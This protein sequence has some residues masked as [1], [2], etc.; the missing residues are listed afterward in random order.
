MQAARL[1]TLGRVLA[2][3]NRC[4]AANSPVV[5]PWVKL[6]Y[7]RRGMVSRESYR[8]IPPRCVLWQ[9]SFS[10]VVQTD[11][12]CPSFWSAEV[13]G[14]GSL[15][16][17][18]SGE[19]AV[20]NSAYVCYKAKAE[21]EPLPPLQWGRSVW[22]LPS[23]CGVCGAVWWVFPSGSEGSGWGQR[24]ICPLNGGMALAERWQRMII[25]PTNADEARAIFLSLDIFAT[26]RVGL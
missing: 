26:I 8:P 12:C 6:P 25:R 10:G 3:Q 19:R 7:G 13:H 22:A 11:I 15:Y 16:R 24:S 21:T 18:N 9:R 5:G 2:E 20:R 23:R 1:F 4:M 14:L 17:A